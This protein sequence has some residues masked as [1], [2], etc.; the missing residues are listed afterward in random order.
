MRR[1]LSRFRILGVASILASWIVGLSQAADETHNARLRVCVLTDI[2]GDPDD[3]QSLV[4]FLTYANE[5]DV[6]GLIATTSCWKQRD[7]DANAIHRVVSAYGKVRSNL[8]LHAPGYPK[9]DYLSGLIKSGV[10]GYGMSAAADQLDNEGIDHIISVVDRSDDRPVWFLSWGGSNTLGGAVM[11]VKKMRSSEAAKAFVARIRGYEIAV[12]D[13]GHAYIAHHFPDAKLISSEL[14]WKGMSRTTPGFNRW[15][16]SRGGNNDVCSHDWVRNHIQTNQGPLGQQYPNAEYLWEGDTPSFLYL[17][18][19]GLG[20]PENPSYGS[21]GGRFGPDRTLNVRS[22]TG[23]KTVD[24]RMDTYRDYSL[25][26]DARDTWTFHDKTYTDNRYAP[27]FRWREAFQHDFQARMDWCVKPYNQANHPPVAV[28]NGRPIQDV[29]P[30]AIVQLNA[31]GSWDPDGDKLS[32]RWWVYREAGSHDGDVAIR[33]ATKANATLTVPNARPGTQI[34][35]ILSVADD[36]QPSLKR[37][38][39]AILTVVAP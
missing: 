14:Q 13:D 18:P 39:R 21:W 33:D 29:R 15:P 8:L 6:E 1:S 5:F 31:M 35:V 23:N 17:I 36:G 24:P 3:Q 20:S 4:R 37:Y 10:D 9:A 25:Y 16:E 27:I 30:N 28:F 26:S 22:G 12:Q 19:N 11:K 32:Y 34:H 38:Q 2:S 7:P